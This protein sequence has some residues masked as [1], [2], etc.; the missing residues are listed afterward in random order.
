MPQEQNKKCVDATTN[1]QQAAEQSLC[2]ENQ[3]LKEYYLRHLRLMCP[4]IPPKVP[5]HARL[6]IIKHR[7]ERLIEMLTLFEHSWAE[8][9]PVL[10]KVCLSYLTEDAVPRKERQ[11]VLEAWTGWSDFQFRLTRYRGLLTQ[12]LQ[13]HHRIWQELESLLNPSDAE[14]SPEPSATIEKGGE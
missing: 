9:V 11:Q 12:F 7:T 5:D 2:A 3:D 6:V 1:N 4:T 10:Q 13:Y 14:T 8:E